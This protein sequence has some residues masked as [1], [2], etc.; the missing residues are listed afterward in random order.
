MCGRPFGWAGGAENQGGAET[1]AT[2]VPFEGIS[3]ALHPHPTL[4]PTP[5]TSLC[6]RRQIQPSTHHSHL[7]RVQKRLLRIEGGE[8]LAKTLK[9][10]DF[11]VELQ[12]Q[13]KKVPSQSKKWP[14]SKSALPK[15][16]RTSHPFTST[17]L[18]YTNIIIYAL[19]HKLPYLIC[20]QYYQI[21][22]E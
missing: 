18:I 10:P 1:F 3:R 7:F 19:T 13:S 8:E 4:T 9:P 11:L 12:S 22:F 16:R 5:Y 21:P 14:P 2:R 15:A 6:Y 20:T 17:R